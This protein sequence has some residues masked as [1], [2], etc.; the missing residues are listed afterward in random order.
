VETVQAQLYSN[1][2]VHF[3]YSTNAQSQS[4]TFTFG[5]TV[6]VSQ[7]NAIAAVPASNLSAGAS[8]TTQLMFEQFTPGTF[9]LGGTTV[10][11][12]PNVSGGYD[13]SVSACVPSRHRNYGTRWHHTP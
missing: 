5:V 12:V 11:F 13:E 10:S 8:S 9:D 7:G 1:G 6:G 3:F 4:T 2:E